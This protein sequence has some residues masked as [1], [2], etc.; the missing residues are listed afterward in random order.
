[1]VIVNDLTMQLTSGVVAGTSANALVG[2]FGNR[3][4]RLQC[5][6]VLLSGA[7]WAGVFLLIMPALAVS[8]EGGT[9]GDAIGY[10]VSSDCCACRWVLPSTPERSN[11][12]RHLPRRILAANDTG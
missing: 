11:G 5:A 6:S 9:H 8:F 3:R 4:L 1:M 10:V 12:D 2:L 7:N